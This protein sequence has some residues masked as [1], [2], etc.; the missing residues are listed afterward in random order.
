MADIG[1]KAAERAVLAGLFAYGADAYDEVADI[2]TERTFTDD[3]NR[4]L[5][6]CLEQVLKERPDAVADFPS[7]LSAAKSLGV[8]ALYEKDEEKKYLRAVVNFPVKKENVREL[9]GKVRRLEIARIMHEQLRIAQADLEQVTGDEP[10][11][12]I[13][14]L[15]EDPVFNLSCLLN[16]TGDGPQPIG[17][18]IRGYVQYLEDN[19]RDVVGIST[20]YPGYDR[21]IGGGLRN[22]TVNMIGARP[23]VGKTMLADNICLHVAGKL[24]VPILNLDTEM[25]KEDH[26]NRML[27]CLTGIPIED[28]ETGK[29]AQNS[30][31]KAK[32]WREME[33][34]EKMPYDYLSIAGQ[35]FEETIAGMRRWRKKV[36]EGKP[37]VVVFDYLK[38]MDT[39]AMKNGNLAEFQVLG[40]MMTSLHNFMVR[41]DCPC[42]AFVQLNR[43]GINRED[44]DVVSQSDRLIW[45]CSNFSIYKKKTDEEIAEQSGGKEVFN[46]KLV[47]IVAR[48]GA[49]VED[50]D[51]I[52][53]MSHGPIAKIVEGPSRNQ[54]HREQGGQKKGSMV[55]DG[56]QEPVAFGG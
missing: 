20:G 56:E 29:F 16:K 3:S 13:L 21:A 24:G 7:I 54:L 31:K 23:K 45:L 32:V 46:R 39:A 52:N 48:H 27:A 15:A 1:D 22:K 4:V 18:G 49:G 40:F 33:S 44:T 34:L 26:W 17:D 2:V 55:D 28:I 6:R 36:G 37:C 43:D 5:Y 38:L 35:P 41:W 47:P 10:I 8:A 25:A 9:A 53:M 14:G 50:G 30:H 12:H 19:Q 51:Y 11:N 42:L